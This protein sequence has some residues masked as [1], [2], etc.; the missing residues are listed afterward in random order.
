VTESERVRVAFRSFLLCVKAGGHAFADA[1]NVCPVCGARRG[2][3]TL[4]AILADN[5]VQSGRGRR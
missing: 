1:V 3:P 5:I 4:A 2:S